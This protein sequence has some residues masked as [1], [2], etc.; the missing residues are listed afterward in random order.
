M[1]GARRASKERFDIGIQ[2]VPIFSGVV[3]Q[4]HIRM[5]QELDPAELE[6]IFRSQPDLVF[7]AKPVS[8][9]RLLGT[10]KIHV[11]RLR[12]DGLGEGFHV[13]VCADNVMGGAVHNVVS[14][15]EHYIERDLL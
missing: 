13:I 1:R 11:G 4:L 7:G 3:I 2:R 10:E 9:K 6:D 12:L 14:L 15:V 5:E 8:P